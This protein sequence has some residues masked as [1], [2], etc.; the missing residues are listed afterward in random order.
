MK[1]TPIIILLL[2]LSSCAPT[3]LTKS[4]RSPE[5]ALFH[6]KN[7]LVIGVTP[8]LETRTAFEL[9]IKNE[10]NA[11]KI[12]ALQSTIVFEK[13][14]Q[15]SHQTETEIEQQVSKL[16]ASGY[17]TVLITTIKGVEDQQSYSGKSSKVDYRLRRFVGYYLAY[18]EAYFNQDYY[19]T[20]KVFHI[21]TLIYNLQK[22]SEKSLVWSGSYDIVDPYD[23]KE[24]T[25]NYVTALLKSL[26]KEKLV[27]KKR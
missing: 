11:R 20:Y 12:N 22:T 9:E 3:N 6:P 21:E 15:D 19:K 8:D 13:A 14:F 18:Q 4:W 1:Y 7:V 25:K 10:L 26:E 5:H 2:F 27:S 16:V 24:S 17:D 23:V